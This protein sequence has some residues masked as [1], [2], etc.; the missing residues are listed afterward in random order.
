[1][2]GIPH[3]Y[4]T[5]DLPGVGGVLKE[6]LEDFIVEEVPLYHP[7]DRG[8]HTF[9]EVEKTDLSTMEALER[10]AGQLAVDIGQFGFAGL[11]D[12]KGITRQGFSVR[13]VAPE[14]VLA[15]RLSQIKIL[16]A[17]LHTNKLRVGHL[18]GNRFRIR[19]RGIE[20]DAQRVDRIVGEVQRLGLPN[21]YGPQRFGNR[22][23]AFRI[24]RALLKWNH[25]YAVRRLLGYPQSTERNPRVVEAR[26]RFMA[27]DLA[28]ALEEFPRSYR[29]ERRLLGY[30]IRSGSNYRGGIRQ[31]AEPVKKLYFSA[32]QSFLFN[33]ILERRLA[34]SQNFPGRL[35]PGDL[36]WIHRNGA[37]FRVAEVD[38][39]QPRADSFEISPS[40]PIFGMKMVSPEGVQARL[41]AE[42][43]AEEGLAATAFHQ[44]M[45]GLHM[46]GGRRPLRVPLRELRYEI[47]GEDLVLEFFLPKG[48][49]ATTFLREI[50][51]REDLPP[52]YQG[53]DEE[54]I[55]GPAPAAPAQPPAAA[56]TGAEAG[57]HELDLDADDEPPLEGD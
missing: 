15:L 47:Q 11:K 26:R 29:Q 57:V 21:F 55:V 30:L 20:P 28:G 54:E 32:Y 19:I 42:L 18:R 27:G 46:E 53:E 10:I 13:L 2:I 39:E 22:G 31:L 41:E 48:S 9:F 37:V 50:M 52:G 1:L 7:A 38:R 8:E 5:A 43:L 24:G 51:K 4:L 44:L 36:A 14:R 16:W 23:D 40:G 6:K 45:P 3:R 12:R 34:E 25:S 17:R 56:E 33:R 35:F 49:Y